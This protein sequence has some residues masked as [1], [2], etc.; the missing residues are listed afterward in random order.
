MLLRQ[1]GWSRLLRRDLIGWNLAALAVV[2]AIGV[3]TLTL[4]PFNVG[5]VGDYIGHELGPSILTDVVEPIVEQ[6]LMPSLLVL[7]IG[8]IAAS[9]LAR[10]RRILLA[11][12]W[13]GVVL[14]VVAILTGPIEPAR[15]SLVALP[16]YCIAGASIASIRVSG[17]F[18]WLPRAILAC[19]VAAQIWTGRTQRPAGAEGYEEAARFVLADGT[20]P[21][22]LF[23]ASVDTGYFV[24]F[25]RKHDPARRLVVL[26]SDKMLTTSLMADLAVK[27]RIKSPEEIYTVL[28][29]FGTKF[30][31][32]ED[33]PTDSRVLNWLRREV[34]T[35]RFIERRRLPL[36]SA[37]HRLLNTSL[38]IYEYREARP[39]DPDAQLELWLPVAG[40]TLH[41]PLRDLQVERPQGAT[42]E[43][44]AGLLCKGGGT[45]NR[46]HANRDTALMFPIVSARS[47][48]ARYAARIAPT[49]FVS[50]SRS[51]SFED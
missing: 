27:N 33:R 14:A 5:V 48:F 34:R 20:A 32:I 7:T 13:I 23:S 24:F 22:V 9:I 39:P 3:A 43:P 38:S 45:E 36:R 25:V 46:R 29:R 16:A 2:I 49:Q 35:D 37:D 19:G 8:G 4:S 40:R 26:R 18:A 17:R 28:E 6:Q 11:L 21:T 15:Y 44:G 1:G 12:F 30:V 10:D 42:R 31:V 50:D 47:T 51:C 41:V